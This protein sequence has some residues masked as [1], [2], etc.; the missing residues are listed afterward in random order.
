M[1]K[2]VGIPT[3]L[4][5]AGFVLAW[6]CGFW[7]AKVGAGD[8]STVSLLFWRFAVV[9]VA[10]WA[11]VGLRGLRVPRAEVRHHVVVGLFS[12]AGYVAPVY[13]AVALGVSTGTTS[14]VDAVQPI[15]VAT[16]AGPLLGLVVRPAQ[17]VG[18][19]GAFVG[20]VMIVRAD[21]VGGAAAGWVYAVPALAVASLVV[22]TLVERGH[23]TSAPLPVMLAIHVTVT[24]V[25]F[26]VP[27][28]LGGDPLPTSPRFWALTAWMAVVPTVG[29]Y[30][31]YWG[32]LRRVD[33]TAL[34]TLLLLVVPTTTLGGVVMFGEPL[35]AL[36]VAGVAVVAAGVV[37]VLRGER[38][39][40]PVAVR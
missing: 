33:V 22:G 28:L 6:S 37:T 7:G 36:T 11:Y 31:L 9:A 24:V 13:V 38:R 12:Q 14:L 1:S 20:V 8:G 35:T 40:Q 5:G 32:L 29:A 30:A 39:Q 25:V 34:N 19:A 16:L 15:V 21:A 3:A 27:N 18:L 4:L 10:L 17:W 2:Q 23:E 26:A